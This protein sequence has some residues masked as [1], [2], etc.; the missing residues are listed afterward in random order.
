MTATSIF[1]CTRKARLKLKKKSHDRRV[2]STFAGAEQSKLVNK[3]RAIENGGLTA[4]SQTERRGKIRGRGV[5]RV[6]DVQDWD[7]GPV[8]YVRTPLIRSTPE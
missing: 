8:Y 4:L 2:L 3:S 1:I 6:S 7:F 5:G